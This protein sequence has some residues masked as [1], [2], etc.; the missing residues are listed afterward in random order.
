M[1]GWNTEREGEGDTHT[2]THTHTQRYTMRKA[3]MCVKA[4]NSYKS[5][6]Q[7]TII[8]KYTPI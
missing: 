3:Y 4:K 7:F 8:I 5:N 2:H 6:M 1:R